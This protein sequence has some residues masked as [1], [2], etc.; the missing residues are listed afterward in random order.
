MVGM[1]KNAVKVALGI[2]SLALL[3]AGV[4]VANAGESYSSFNTTVGKFNGNGYTGLQTK[5]DGFRAG[6]LLMGTV[7]G[8]Y[9]VDARMDDQSGSSR[10][11]WIRNLG[12]GD[13]GRLE[14]SASAGDKVKVQFSND[15]STPVSVQ[16][17]GKWASN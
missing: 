4:G 17:T 3:A 2:S 1:R 15:A 6:P 10:G 9:E 13:V 8:S 7:G 14:N 16:V 5:K 11:P 12:D